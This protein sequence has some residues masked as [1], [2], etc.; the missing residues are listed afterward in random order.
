MAGQNRD[1]EGRKTIA[2]ARRQVA[3]RRAMASAEVHHQAIL[4]SQCRRMVSE[5]FHS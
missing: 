2:M 1:P 4:A 3:H 5:F